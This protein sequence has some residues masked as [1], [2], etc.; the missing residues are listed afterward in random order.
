MVSNVSVK[1]QITNTNAYPKF[2]KSEIL[3]S[4]LINIMRYILSSFKICFIWCHCIYH[5]AHTSNEINL[6]QIRH[7]YS[8]TFIQT[9]TEFVYLHLKQRSHLSTPEMDFG[10]YLYNNAVSG[11]F[12]NDKD[13]FESNLFVFQ[14]KNE[15]IK[16]KATNLSQLIINSLVWN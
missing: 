12:E 10:V 1:Q 15:W 5:T 11:K 9:W 13:T 16:I 4:Y 6:V 2:K 7:F 14:E 8:V 3:S